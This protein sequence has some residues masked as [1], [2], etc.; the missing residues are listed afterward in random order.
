M[1]P[2]AESEEVV[3]ISLHSAIGTLPS[4]SEWHN[5]GQAPGT[6]GT[7]TCNMARNE[8]FVRINRIIRAASKWLACKYTL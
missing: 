4:L 6:K 1:L 8:L 2:G 3:P 5:D 7:G